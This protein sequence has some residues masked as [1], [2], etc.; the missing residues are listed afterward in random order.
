MDTHTE[1]TAEQGRAFCLQSLNPVV[2]FLPMNSESIPRLPT[3]VYFA[4]LDAAGIKD[5]ETARQLHVSDATIARWRNGT[6]R[7]TA[8]HHTALMDF[9]VSLGTIGRAMHR[10]GGKGLVQQPATGTAIAIQSYGTTDTYDWMAA[11][12]TAQLAALTA[13]AQGEPTTWDCA[14]IQRV[15]QELDGMGRAL[16]ILQPPKENTCPA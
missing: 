3:S 10:I 1:C 4:M 7:L 2:R 5:A 11:V 6:R 16:A 14:A 13:L 15:G 12:W 8:A 9:A